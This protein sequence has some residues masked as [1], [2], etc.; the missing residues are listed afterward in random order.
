MGHDKKQVAV[1]SMELLRDRERPYCSC[2][3]YYGRCGVHDFTANG[4]WDSAYEIYFQLSVDNGA[5]ADYNLHSEA[6]DFADSWVEYR[7]NN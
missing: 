7:E 5:E 4:T 3:Q 2:H 6:V 1:D